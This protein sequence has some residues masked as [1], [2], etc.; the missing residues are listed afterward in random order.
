M[1]ETVNNTPWG[2]LRREKARKNPEKYEFRLGETFA[3]LL[4][5][6]RNSRHPPRFVLRHH[7]TK[8]P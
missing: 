1:L 3:F 6:Q 4:R 8:T 7:S 2:T 5:P